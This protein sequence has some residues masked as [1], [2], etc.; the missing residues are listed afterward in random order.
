M[1]KENEAK[2]T[3]GMVV[4]ITDMSYANEF[5]ATSGNA[6]N[7]Y[8]R[9]LLIVSPPNELFDTINVIPF[10]SKNRPGIH[11]DISSNRYESSVLM[12]YDIFT[13]DTKKISTV[14]CIVPRSVMQ[15]VDKAIMYHLGYTEEVPPYLKDLDEDIVKYNNATIDNI[16]DKA[17]MR[18]KQM[19]R[20]SSINESSPTI[21]DGA[22]II[23][24]IMTV[25]R[26]SKNAIEVRNLSPKPVET[27]VDAIAEPIIEKEKEYR[28]EPIEKI[29][30]S[31][32]RHVVTCRK[33]RAFIDDARAKLDDKNIAVILRR[34]TTIKE[35]GKLFD[36]SA[37][38]AARLREELEE[39]YFGSNY[40]KNIA[41][42]IGN[43]SKNFNSLN[44]RQKVVLSIY[45]SKYLPAYINSDINNLRRF[46]N[47]YR[48]INHIHLTDKR[49]WGNL[50]ENS[51][52]LTVM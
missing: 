46:I 24:K 35:M 29:Y 41:K 42:A 44:E 19:E 6:I 12:P 1:L 20:Y 10:T 21:G 40:C 14:K 13:I 38:S 27:V 52:Y 25:N 8:G 47:N 28:E 34:D 2:F 18:T 26:E 48:R 7:L 23:N 15:A 11:Y 3:K 39:T 4:Y 49:K 17:D 50:S 36:L 32:E 33:P 45:M 16:W 43:S 37:S 22:R 9:P 51:D 5:R 30:H 31:S